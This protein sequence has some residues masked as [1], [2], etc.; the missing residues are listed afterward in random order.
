MAG[1]DLRH[2]WP[3]YFTTEGDCDLAS[4]PA[5]AC[6]SAQPASCAFINT[7]EHPVNCYPRVD[8]AGCSALVMKPRFTGACRYCSVRNSRRGVQ[9]VGIFTKQPTP[10][11]YRVVRSVWYPY[12]AHPAQLAA[13]MNPTTTARATTAAPSDN[14]AALMPRCRN[15]AGE[16]RNA[17]RFLSR[18][19]AL[20]LRL[21]HQPEQWRSC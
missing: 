20:Q 12:Q 5:G 17:G 13:D 9:P 21:R 14:L 8:G 1:A 16:D 19:Q 15:L 2:G 18:P 7:A 3:C 11:A 4:Y 10:N 6:L